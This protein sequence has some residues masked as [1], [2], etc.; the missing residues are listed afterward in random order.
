MHD[1]NVHDLLEANKNLELLRFSTAGSVDDG[2]STLIG[3]LL[4]DS[5]SIYEDQ[6]SS[7]EKDSKKLNRS[8]DLALLTDGLQ[9]ERE[10]GIT[11]DVAYRYFSTPK[12]RFIIADTPGHEQY[13]RNMATGA[14][15]ADV[16]IILVDAR[17]GVLIQSKRHAF[18]SSLLGIKRIVLAVNKM[19]LVDYDEST[20][21][22]IV[23]EFKGY[24]S[25]LGFS[26][27]VPI[28]ISALVGDNVVN[29]S[30]RTPWYKGQTIIEYLE[31]V[32]IQA[33][34]NLQ[35]FRFPVQLVSRPNSDFR[36]FMGTI[37]SGIIRVGVEVMVLPSMQKSTVKS[38]VTFDGELQEAYTPMA[39]T[40]TLNDEIDVSR[41]CVLTKPKNTPMMKAH[42]DADIVWMG[43]E[44][45]QIGDEVLIKHACSTCRASI[46][47]IQ[48]VFDPKD[49]TRHAQNTLQLN[50]IARVSLECFKE[51]IC[52]TYKNNKVMGNFIMIDAHS[53]ATI[54]AGMILNK[55]RVSDPADTQSTIK[56]KN[57]TAIT[58]EV[59][60]ASREKLLGHKPATIWFTGLSGSGKSTIAIALEQQLFARNCLCFVY[61]G[62]NLRF[63]LNRDLGFSDN[64]RKENIRRV[65]E[66]AKLFNQAGGIAITSFISPFEDGRA[67]AQN[68]I[69]EGCIQVYL[70]V[71]VEECANRDPKG[72]YKK[73]YAGEIAN[74]TGVS[75]TFEP[76]A[77]P[78][79]RID[80]SACRVDEAV[81][82]IIQ[83]L[84]ERGIIN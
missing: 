18:I 59:T 76:P 16:A 17:H 8:I 25:K 14:S 58:Q 69:G 78:D 77:T 51:V 44:D 38:I 70:D 82:Q 79:L 56:S 45:A 1:Q 71:D 73:A 24:C 11:I 28:P 26:D 60:A 80:T 81:N 4:Y 39:I 27:I 67:L 63:G 61:D 62:D 12:R 47:E 13:T 19:D 35:D 41:G 55:I 7:V 84:I 49:L 30:L 15:T 31:N 42:L 48:Y 37:A 5:K 32:Y 10:Q 22:R 34:K 43:E 21:L 65:A 66:V 72:L 9:A 68:I 6:L 20:F 33:D 75:S 40:L 29:P 74:F 53:N 54:A 50:Q 36:G 57:I 3:R 46:T 83:Y 23:S 64:D 52:D 2:K